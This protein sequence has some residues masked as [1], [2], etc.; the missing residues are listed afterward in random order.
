MLVR[1]NV[2]DGTAQKLERYHKLL[3]LKENNSK[4]VR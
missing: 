1:A 4:Q 2:V 3:L